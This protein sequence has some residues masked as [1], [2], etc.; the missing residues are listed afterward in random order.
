MVKTFGAIFGEKDPP[1]SDKQSNAI[2]MHYI[3]TENCL[4][5][6]VVIDKYLK[7]NYLVSIQ[8]QDIFCKVKED[9]DFNRGNTLSILRIKI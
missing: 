6:Y 8:K 3:F 5:L 9:E 1:E 2:S 4:N 7:I